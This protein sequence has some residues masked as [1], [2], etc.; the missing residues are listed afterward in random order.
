MNEAKHT[1]NRNKNHV[2]IEINEKSIKTC[3][4][5]DDFEIQREFNKK[6]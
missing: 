5:K 6:K 1:T 2:S 4:D 3:F